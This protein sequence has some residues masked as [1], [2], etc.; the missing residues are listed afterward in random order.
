MLD[1]TPRSLVVSAL[2]VSV[3]LLLTTIERHLQQVRATFMTRRTRTA[4]RLS[5]L[6]SLAAS[7]VSMS[8]GLTQRQLRLPPDLSRF[9]ARLHPLFLPKQKKGSITTAAMP[10][11]VEV[12]SVQARLPAVLS[13]VT[14]TTTL[15]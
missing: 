5:I 4:P 7:L 1:A 6:A 9:Q 11:L 14:G 12:L 3:L 13:L 8:S 10:P 2:R 15:L